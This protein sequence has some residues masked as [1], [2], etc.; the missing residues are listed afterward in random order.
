[1]PPVL[2]VYRPHA[3]LL[4]ETVVIRLHGPDRVKMEERTGKQWDRI[5]EPREADLD[6]LASVVRGLRKRERKVWLFANN[7]FEGC[8]PLTIE[9]LRQKIDV[10]D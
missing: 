6:A 10:Q 5:V 1:M 3:D 9:R 4:A 2:D 8:A 7:H